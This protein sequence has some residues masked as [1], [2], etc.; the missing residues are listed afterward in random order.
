MNGARAIAIAAVVTVGL[1]VPAAC[2]SSSKSSSSD[3]AVNVELADY[4]IKPA[5]S[6][7]AA[8][9]VTFKVHNGGTFVHEFVV[10]KSDKAS[11]I[12]VKADGTADEDSIPEADHMGEVEDV[13]PGDSTEL[14]VTLPA[15]KYVLLCNR[16]DGTTSHF[17]KG[18]HVEFT[19]N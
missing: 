14:K 3:K 19:V 11:A 16:V 4:S 13:N 8:G 7:A 10:V 18:M 1:L 12:E 5:S 6:S 17:S 9:E 15:G 2:G